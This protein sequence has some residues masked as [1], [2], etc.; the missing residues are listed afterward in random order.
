VNSINAAAAALPKRVMNSRR[1]I[2]SPTVA[3]DKAAYRFNYRTESG[4]AR[5]CDVLPVLPHA[6][7]GFRLL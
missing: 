3:Q 1:L 6:K 7:I 5:A 4:P 2:A